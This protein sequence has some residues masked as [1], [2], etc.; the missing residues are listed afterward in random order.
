MAMHMRCVFISQHATHRGGGGRW[1]GLRVCPPDPAEEEAGVGPGAVAAGRGAAARRRMT[2]PGVRCGGA[3][4]GGQS[5][6]MSRR[7]VRNDGD[8]T[9]GG[10]GVVGVTAG[11]R[12]TMTWENAAAMGE[13]IELGNCCRF[14][15][16]H[17]VV[18]ARGWTGQKN[19]AEGG[20]DRMAGWLGD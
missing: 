20:Q 18:A 15:R 7:A 3:G 5:E 10:G 2:G 17:D 19:Q 9:R 8:G 12:T 1:E 14:F 13:R 11:Y 6:V 16:R 4:R